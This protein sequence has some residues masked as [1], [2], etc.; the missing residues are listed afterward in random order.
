MYL[1]TSSASC[2]VLINATRMCLSASALALSPQL[3]HWS[4]PDMRWAI[5]HFEPPSPAKVPKASSPFSARR[6]TAGALSAGIRWES[7]GMSV[8]PGIRHAQT[9]PLSGEDMSHYLWSGSAVPRRGLVTLSEVFFVSWTGNE[10]SPAYD[11]NSK[12]TW[13]SHAFCVG[14]HWKIWKC[15]S[16]FVNETSQTMHKTSPQH[17][18]PS[19]RHQSITDTEQRHHQHKTKAS[20]TY[21]QNITETCPRHH[22]H[23][24]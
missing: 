17:H 13:N 22:Q 3:V 12:D 19:L 7:S 8:E 11:P 14:T 18:H 21:H 1:Y 23:I 16:M 10:I 15:S 4:S 24:P 5:N 2:Y 9:M 6:E 20:S